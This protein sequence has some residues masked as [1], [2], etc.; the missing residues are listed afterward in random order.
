MNDSSELEPL[1]TFACSVCSAV[2][3]CLRS[4]MWMPWWLKKRLQVVEPLVRLAHERGQVVLEG[5]DLV[6]DRLREH[7]AD[8]RRAPAAA[9]GR[10]AGSRR[11]AAGRAR[12]RKL[13]NGLRISAISDATMMISTTWRA[14]RAAT[15]SASSAEQRAGRAGRPAGSRA[16]RAARRGSCSGSARRQR[17]AT[18]SR[19]SVLICGSMAARCPAADARI[20]FCGDLVG[21]RGPPAR[22]CATAAACCAN[23]TTPTFVVVNAENVAGGFGIT[24]DDRRRAAR[25]RRRRDHARQPRLPPPRD[26]PLPRRASRGSCAPRTTCAASPATATRSSSATASASR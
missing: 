24:P 1:R 2:W 9:T 4:W 15:H 20:L 16:A 5:V 25:G 8:R 7:E 12:P 3:P 11:R 22:C 21:L 26:L 6:G 19:C 17:P 23:A 10:S 13:T 14:A 18:R